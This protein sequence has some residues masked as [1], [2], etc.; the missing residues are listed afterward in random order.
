MCNGT[1]GG[2][3]VNCTTL[4]NLQPVAT[5]YNCPPTYAYSSRGGTRYAPLNMNIGPR[6]TQPYSVVAGMCCYIFVSNN[7]QCQWS[8]PYP[9]VNKC[10]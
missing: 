1:G 7:A 9:V 8:M 10:I 5:A 6:I 2:T 4:C 3:S